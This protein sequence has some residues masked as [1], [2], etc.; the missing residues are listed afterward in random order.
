MKKYILLSFLLVCF[1]HLTMGQTISGTLSALPNKALRLEGFEGLK[2]YLIDST[3]TDSHGNFT[4]TFNTK[5]YGMGFLSTPENKPLI[6]I[7]VNEDVE[8]KGSLPDVLETLSFIKG[9]QNKAF[10][11][12]SKDHPKREQ[13]LSAYDYLNKMY[14]TEPLFN[15]HKKPLKAIQ[16]EK[17]RIKVEDA[18]F[19]NSLP[20]NSY[21]AWFLPI[22]KLISNVPIVAQYKPEEIPATLAALRQIDYSDPRLYK[23]GLFRDAIESQVW[24]IEN[25][26]GSLDSVFVE[27]NRSIDIILQSLELDESKYNEVTDYLFNL[28]ERRSLFTSSEYLALKVLNDNSCTI[29]Q[30]L[31]FQLETYRTMKKGN[32]APEIIFPQT[33]FLPIHTQSKKLSEIS[34]EYTLV[35]FAAGWCSHCIEEIPKIKPLYTK[36]LEK[37]VEVVLVSLDETPAEFEKFVAEFPFISTCDFKKWDSPIAKDYFIFGTPTMFLLDKDRKIVLRPSSVKQVEAWVDWYIK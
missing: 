11:R 14:L 3:I 19:L 1:W 24:F 29:K 18:A 5:D 21:V 9:F 10:E 28:L 13:A 16:T 31:A 26:S 27:L 25:T 15:K 36:W 6:L 35:V 12:Y 33:T 2:T 8:V 22:R 32:T 34:S 7:L 20:N 30:D 17:N 4:L 23:S 37:G